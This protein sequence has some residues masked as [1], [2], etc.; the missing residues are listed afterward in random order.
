MKEQN[1][2]DQAVFPKESERTNLQNN[3]VGQASIHEPTDEPW[4]W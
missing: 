1:L 3:F 2:H 4:S